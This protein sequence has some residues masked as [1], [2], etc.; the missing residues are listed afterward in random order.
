[1]TG[2]FYMLVRLNICFL[3]AFATLAMAG[4]PEAKAQA[5]DN[6]AA[7]QQ[8]GALQAQIT[9]GITNGTLS[10]DQVAALQAQIAQLNNAVARNAALPS[11]QSSATPSAIEAQRGAGLGYVGQG[12][13]ETPVPLGTSGTTL[14]NQVINRQG[15][16]TPPVTAPVTT[17][18]QTG[19][20]PFTYNTLGPDAYQSQK[21]QNP[22][23]N[24]PAYPTTVPQAAG[25]EQQYSAPSAGAPYGAGY[26]QAPGAG[27]AAPQVYVYHP[28]MSR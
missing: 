16:V 18:P 4:I 3:S 7:E 8:E 14:Q 17:Q 27:G 9:Q 20:D 24:V 11:S 1:M 23:Y 19:P 21:Y 13:G 5:L 26:G 10:A 12:A 25:T 28:S 6:S 22:A 2:L 15:A